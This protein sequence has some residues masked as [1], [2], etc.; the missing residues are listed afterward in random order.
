MELQRQE[1]TIEGALLRRMIPLLCCFLTNYVNVVVTTAG[2]VIEN[3]N[4]NRKRSE[5]LNELSDQ[6]ENSEPDC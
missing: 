1:T 5:Q 6:V 3:Q 2:K 4:E